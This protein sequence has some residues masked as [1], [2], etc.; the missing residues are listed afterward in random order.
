MIG[1][2]G[3]LILAISVVVDVTIAAGVAFGTT[4]LFHVWLGLDN[5]I[6]LAAIVAGVILLYVGATRRVIGGTAGERLTGVRYTA[7]GAL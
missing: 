5:V 2:P 4:D 3:A 6:L 1:E 7:G